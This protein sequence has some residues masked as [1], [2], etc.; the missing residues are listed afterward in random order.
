M[1]AILFRFGQKC[2]EI[3]HIRNFH[4]HTVMTVKVI[5]FLASGKNPDEL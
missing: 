4:H 2:I 3:H 5:Y 1:T